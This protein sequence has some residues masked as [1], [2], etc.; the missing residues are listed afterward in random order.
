M[1]DLASNDVHDRMLSSAIFILIPAI[2]AQTYIVGT[3]DLAAI[4]RFELL[5]DA[6]C[7]IARDS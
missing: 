7:V 3:M 2:I 6:L 5:Y 1:T 4:P